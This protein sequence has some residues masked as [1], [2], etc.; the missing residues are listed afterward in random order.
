M[1]GS[2][3]GPAEAGVPDRAAPQGD[4]RGHDRQGRRPEGGTRAPG[5]ARREG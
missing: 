3:G 4:R 1:Q 5:E 2:G